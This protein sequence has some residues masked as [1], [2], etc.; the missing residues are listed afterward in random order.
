[1][2]LKEVVHYNY[3]DT[4]GNVYC[5]KLHKIITI[6]DEA[7][8]EIDCTQCPLFFGSLQGQG[9]EC[10]W[11]DATEYMVHG[12][13]RPTKELLRVSQLIDN[14]ILKKDI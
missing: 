3:A 14:G 1:M 4:N 6:S 11:D 13:S 12:A 8:S 10:V 5:R 7:T 9:V 2:K